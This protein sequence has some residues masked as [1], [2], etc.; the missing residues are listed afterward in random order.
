MQIYKTRHS[1]E[2][3]SLVQK[4]YVGYTV[5]VGEGDPEFGIEVSGL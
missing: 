1:E 5:V 4:S 2:N 3:G